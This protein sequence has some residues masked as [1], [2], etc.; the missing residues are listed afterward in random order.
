MAAMKV[1]SDS[2]E[3]PLQLS[4]VWLTKRNSS[5][6]SGVH[7]AEI[8]GLNLLHLADVYASF[9]VTYGKHKVRAAW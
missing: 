6:Q 1:L 4:V 2:P 3:A 7:S 5:N 9:F 8:H